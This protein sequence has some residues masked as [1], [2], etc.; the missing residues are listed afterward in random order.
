MDARV[1]AALAGSYLLGSIPFAYLAVRWRAGIDIRTA[2]SKN[3][4]ATNAGRILGRPWAVAIYVAD[5]GKGAG[6]VVM[7]REAAGAGSLVQVGCA[8]LAIVGHLFPVWLRFR[9]GKGV[10]TTTG[11][12]A[13][14]APFAFLIGGATWCLVA[15][16]SRYVSLASVALA[17]ALPVAVVAL[18]PEGAFGAGLPVTGLAAAAA[19]FVVLRHVPNLQRV[20]AG[21]EPKIFAKPRGGDA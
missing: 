19:V 3:V 4:G 18:D 20:R 13:A 10:A 7:A 9:G 12:F 2:G 16:T 14:L 8:L 6:A 15:A 1:A 11:V 17:L 5:A 21:T